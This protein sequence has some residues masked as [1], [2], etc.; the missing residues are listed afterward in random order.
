MRIDEY[1]KK[2]HAYEADY[3][4]ERLVKGHKN[5]RI[6]A[7]LWSAIAE[8]SADVG[9]TL[10]WVQ[11]VAEEIGKNVI[12]GKD[13]DAAPAALKA[14]GFW[15]RIDSDHATREMMK[16]LMAFEDDDKLPLAK[17]PAP[18]W[19]LCLRSHG[20][21]REVRDKTA[22]NKINNWLKELKNN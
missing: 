12:N 6:A 14:I 13:R 3:D 22:E 11:H 9:E 2:P 5:S 21:L 7:D 4:L 17:W 20:Y 18:K 19:L 1:L 8:G 15:G 16:I 10:I